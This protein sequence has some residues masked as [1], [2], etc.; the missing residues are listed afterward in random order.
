LGRPSADTTE[1]LNRKNPRARVR[2][3]FI[4]ILLSLQKGNR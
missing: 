4:L 3:H 2:R 1:L